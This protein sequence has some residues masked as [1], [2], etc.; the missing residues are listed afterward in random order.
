MNVSVVVDAVH[1]VLALGHVE[2]K[3]SRIE[4]HLEADDVSIRMP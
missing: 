2:Q 4:H 3:T 1:M